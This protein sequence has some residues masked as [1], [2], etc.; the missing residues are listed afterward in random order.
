M[1]LFK[2]LQLAIDA[3][4]D[5]TKD[6]SYRVAKL[7]RGHWR[8]SSDGKKNDVEGLLCRRVTPWHRKKIII[9]RDIINKGENL[10]TP[11]IRE[12]QA[13]ILKISYNILSKVQIFL[14]RMW[15]ILSRPPS[16]ATRWQRA[17]RDALTSNRSW[18]M[19]VKILS[20]AWRPL[21]RMTTESVRI[22]GK[23]LSSE[24]I[25]EVMRL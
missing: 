4:D 14:G 17:I 20:L 24:G 5:Y 8:E 10:T 25:R 15:N 21:M 23:W 22:G 18:P 12:N 16:R 7:C 11:E 3:K 13:G 1:I 2:R 6:H 9:D 19:G